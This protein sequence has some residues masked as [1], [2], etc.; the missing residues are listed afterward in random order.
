MKT[1]DKAYFNFS[2]FVLSSMLRFGKISVYFWVILVIL[3][4]FKHKIE[5]ITPRR[6]SII[7]QSKNQ[8]R[9]NERFQWPIEDLYRVPHFT[10]TV[11][12]KGK[13]LLID[14]HDFN[15]EGKRGIRTDLEKSV[16]EIS[17]ERMI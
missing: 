1:S 3:K 12:N 2:K 14:E 8:S 16:Y 13:D 11:L 7:E 6:F 17:Q 9:R 15:E 4:S 5:T 10:C